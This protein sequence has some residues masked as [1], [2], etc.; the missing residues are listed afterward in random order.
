MEYDGDG[1]VKK[2]SDHGVSWKIMYNM[3]TPPWN[4]RICFVDSK[5]RLFVG[6][7]NGAIYRSM[8]DGNSFHAV[9]RPSP[10]ERYDEAWRMVEAPNNDLY[11]GMHINPPEVWKSNDG[12]SAWHIVGDESDFGSIDSIGGNDI[13]GLD[14]NQNTGW[15]YVVP[16]TGDDAGIYRSKDGGDT[17]MH[18]TNDHE[19]RL[20]VVSY[21]SEKIF[22]TGEAWGK[23]KIGYI[24]DDGTDTLKDI[25][26]VYQSPYEAR[27]F[28]WG[29]VIY[30]NGVK[31][32]WFGSGAT[33]R[34]DNRSDSELI[35][36]EDGGQ[37]WE[38]V[39]IKT[40]SRGRTSFYYATSHPQ[41]GGYLYVSG[42]D[43]STRI[44]H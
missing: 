17:W 19:Y 37:S 41:R 30:S 8:D 22:V 31:Q 11:I 27:P 1:T 34:L 14:V 10:P 35:Y 7:R 13:N 25:T 23:N 39:L 12:G 28:I 20:T 15:I 2:S 43:N 29:R 40:N 32:L 6:G 44:A 26:T 21:D 38:Q 16:D 24:V 18:L 5:N 3:K 4:A 42:E 9:L 33:G 36:S